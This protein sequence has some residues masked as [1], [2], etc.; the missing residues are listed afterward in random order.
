MSQSSTVA[1]TITEDIA[2]VNHS[3]SEMNK[4]S[5]SIKESSEQLATLGRDLRALVAQFKLA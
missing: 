1:Q 5:T 2:D 3:S 4:S